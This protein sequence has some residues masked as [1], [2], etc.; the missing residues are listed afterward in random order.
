[1]ATS[2]KGGKIQSKIQMLLYGEQGCGKSTICSQLLYLKRPDGKPFRVLYLDAE[3]GSIDDMQEELEENGVDLDNLYVVYT[4]SLKEVN[5]YIDKATKKEPFYDL[6]D[7]GN[8]TDE[9]I[10]DADGEQFIPDAIVVDGTTI[11]N[12]SVKQGLV[13]F[14]KTR[15]S[16]K[17]KQANLLGDEK[18]VKIEG[19]G[20]ELKD[21]NAINFKG[22]DLVLT[23]TGS[24][25][26]YIITAR[27]TDDKKTI[28]NSEGKEVTVVT[29]KKIAEGFKNMGFNVK[30]EMRLFREKNDPEIVKAFVVK[31]RTHT[32]PNG[33][34]VEDP[35]LLPFQAVIDRTKDYK[36]GNIQN[37]LHDAIKKEL[38]ETEKEVLGEEV[39]IENE[40]EE[41]TSNFNIDEI[42][43][44][45]T[46]KMRTLTIIQQQAV[47]EKLR[48]NDL[49]ST[50]SKIKSETSEEIL[51]K[52]IDLLG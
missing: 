11:L 28:T 8:E 51:L 20:L 48:S 6:D 25:L 44:Q 23:L 47:K 26:H 7:E 37:R 21:Y 35:S 39:K 5:D 52:I 2:R 32:Y 4:Q 27:E 34:T 36:D 38:H 24:G 49:P 29:G 30:T 3:S 10:L 50:P 43:K 41:K 19:A 31:D 13:E 33:S 15:A 40:L 18:F 9:M 1:M 45:I 12:L 22:Q 16:V 17:A 46:S 42:K 14:S